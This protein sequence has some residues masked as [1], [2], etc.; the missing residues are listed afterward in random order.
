MSVT[1]DKDQSKKQIEKKIER[2]SKEKEGKRIDAGKYF[3][4]I[5]F[6]VDGLT[7][8]KRVRDEWA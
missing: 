5:D 6:G 4:K 3:G 1:I 8:Q 7:F 2:V